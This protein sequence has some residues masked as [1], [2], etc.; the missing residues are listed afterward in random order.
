MPLAY[1]AFIAGMFG[2]LFG[3]FW[4]NHNFLGISGDID[5]VGLSFW[6]FLFGT[7]ALSIYVGY[8]CL[9]AVDKLIDK[10][11]GDDDE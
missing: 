3:C 2:T 5:R 1:L 10:A 4:I 8:L 6:I 11:L 9:S 7:I